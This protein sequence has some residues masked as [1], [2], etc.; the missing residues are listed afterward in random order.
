MG[1]LNERLLGHSGIVLASLLILEALPFE[2]SPPI[3][4]ISDMDV[5]IVFTLLSSIRSKVAVFGSMHGNY[6][7]EVGLPQ[8]GALSTALFVL[9][10]ISLYDALCDADT[11]CLVSDNSRMFS[12]PACGYVDDVALL[13]SAPAAAQPA[14]KVAFEWAKGIRMVFNV[15]VDK[16][17]C[18]VSYDGSAPTADMKF[19]DGQSR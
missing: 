4:G 13:T 6:K 2:P 5:F 14:L 12:A 1:P 3:R 16:S 18:L 9:L 17:A 8:G 19:P 10:T 15:G 11:A 7:N